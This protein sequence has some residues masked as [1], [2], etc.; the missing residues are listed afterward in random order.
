LPRGVG[1][2]ACHVG[3]PADVLTCCAQPIS[4]RLDAVSKNLDLRTG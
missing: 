4:T 1:L 2:L 3:I